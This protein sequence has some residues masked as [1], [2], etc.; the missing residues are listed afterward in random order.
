MAP[1][2][3]TRTKKRATPKP[4][5]PR[6]TSK[7]KKAKKKVTKRKP[8][9]TT[10]KAKTKKTATNQTAAIAEKKTNLKEK[11]NT[12][13]TIPPPKKTAKKKEEKK[14][15]DFEEAKD[16][17]SNNINLSSNHNANVI[18]QLCNMAKTE[19]QK[20]HVVELANNL[21][22]E[23]VK[24]QQDQF[25]QLLSQLKPNSNAESEA[26][27]F[28]KLAAK[29]TTP[30]SNIAPTRKKRKHKRGPAPKVTGDYKHLNLNYSGECNCEGVAKSGNACG[31][32]SAS[33]NAWGF[34]CLPLCM[35]IP[36]CGWHISQ[37]PKLLE[38]FTSKLTVE[39]KTA[40]VNW[41]CEETTNHFF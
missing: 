40:F 5:K 29:I 21:I 9:R 14:Q 32:T 19:E 17:I 26:Q 24:A 30:Q 38:D 35:N 16:F 25:Q 15:Y 23:Y 41:Y 34:V 3:V 18:L 10:K 36:A 7:R 39:D 2:K 13:E 27:K 6:K 33:G 28:E 4:R 12:A 20:T 31:N 37:F 22:S 8:K 11:K 1:A